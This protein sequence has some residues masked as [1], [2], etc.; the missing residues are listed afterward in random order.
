MTDHNGESDQT[1]GDLI[2][3]P[4]IDIREGAKNTPRGGIP[5]FII[6]FLGGGTNFEQKWGDMKF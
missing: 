6:L 5:L 1:R 3:H 2:N 4:F